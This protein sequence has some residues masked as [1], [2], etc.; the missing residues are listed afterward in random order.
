M[1]RSVRTVLLASFCSAARSLNAPVV[2]LTGGKA[3][4]FKAGNPLVYGGAVKSVSGKPA[5]GAVVDVVDG[6]GGFIGWGVFNPISMY[7]VRLLAHEEPALLAHR[8]IEQ[9]LQHRLRA[10]MER[11]RALRLPSDENTAYR[12]VNGEGDRLSGLMVDVYAGVAVAVSSAIWLE[13]WSDAVRDALLELPEV[14][15]VVWRRNLARLKQDGWDARLKQDG[16]DADDEQQERPAATA[17][18]VLESGLKYELDPYGQKSGFYCDQ[19][20][21]REMLARLC[22]GQ[23]VLDL[24]CFSGGFAISAVAAGATSALGIDS[25]APALALAQR[26]AELNGL[27]DACAFEKHDVLKFLKARD[28]DP[29]AEPFDV[30]ICDPPKLAPSVKDLPRATPRYRKINALAMRALR[31]GGLLLTCTCSA[32]M[33]QSEGKFV[34]TV[35]EAALDE[36]RVL[37]LL[38]TTGAAADHVMNPA[39]P[40]SRYLTAA[41]FVVQ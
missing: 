9:L 21:N 16:G 15:S 7:R 32:A 4:L 1:M 31:P 17:V 25:S 28:E 5:T 10:A 18:E 29:D 20:D 13:N 39:Y 14:T 22:G 38:R 2:T 23:R 8:D 36:G 30:V 24:F 35:Q 27:G 6:S 12:L 11:R 26:N 41:L 37:T 19:R 40:E 34:R 3:K 33:S